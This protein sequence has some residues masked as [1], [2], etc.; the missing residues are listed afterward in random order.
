MSTTIA[1]EWSGKALACRKPAARVGGDR[2][3]TDPSGRR[4][5]GVG[6]VDRSVDEEPRGRTVDVCEE[7]P[8]VELD[9]LALAGSDQLGRDVVVAV[10]H[11]P[12]AAVV[13]VDEEDGATLVARDL[14]ELSEQ[15]C[16][17]LVDPD[18]DLAPARKS[19]AEREIVRDS[20]G[21]QPRLAADEH[22][23][24]G[25]DH[26]ALDAA[27]GHRACQLAVLRDDQLGADR[28]RRRA[29]SRNDASHRDPVTASAP[30]I[31]LGEEFPH[32]LIVALG[33]EAQACSGSEARTTDRSPTV[34]PVECAGLARARFP[35][36]RAT[37][38]ER[39]RQL[40]L[41]SGSGR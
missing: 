21:E 26:F 1:V 7:T 6:R 23:A 28:P 5:E 19:D 22:L 27:A 3:P 4:T 8:S 38:V 18:V 24:R 15:V 14:R 37:P 20:I 41:V 36:K 16:I 25:L 9:D 33:W 11:E 13:E 30:A 34:T 12:L 31:K 35:A 40:S 32:G 2:V 10:E 39:K 29:P 17:G